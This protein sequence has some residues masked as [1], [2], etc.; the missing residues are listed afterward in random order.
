MVARL[1]CLLLPHLLPSQHVWVYSELVMLVSAL[2]FARQNR[3][4][5]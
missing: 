1:D 2:G 3:G 5:G 4:R